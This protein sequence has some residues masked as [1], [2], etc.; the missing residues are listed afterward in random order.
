VEGLPAGLYHYN[1]LRHRIYR[2]REGDYSFDISNGLIQRNLAVDA[3]L[4][5]FVTAMFERSVFKYG[6]RGY[7]FVLI[8]AGHLAQNLTLAAMGLG[9]GAL[10]IGGYVDRAIDEFLELDGINHSTVYMMAVGKPAQ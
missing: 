7:R 8:E 2:L 9:F 6:D 1:A 3:S 5:V 4:I 10:N